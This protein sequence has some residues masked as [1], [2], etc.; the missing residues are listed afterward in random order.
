MPAII[1]IEP[2]VGIEQVFS[3]TNHAPGPLHPLAAE[4]IIGIII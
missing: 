1:R 4:G 3:D 2:L